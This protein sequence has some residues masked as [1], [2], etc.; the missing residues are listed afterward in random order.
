MWRGAGTSTSCS[1]WRVTTGS[2]RGCRRGSSESRTCSGRSPGWSSG[3]RAWET[4][5]RGTRRRRA[6][7]G[8]GSRRSRTKCCGCVSPAPRRPRPRPWPSIGGCAQV[9][10]KVERL[11][12]DRLHLPW[13]AAEDDLCSRLRLLTRQLQHPAHP[14]NALN[15]LGPV[16]R[17][18]EGTRVCPG[19][20]TNTIVGGPKPK[21]WYMV[22]LSSID[23]AFAIG[24]VK[25]CGER[26]LISLYFSVA[27]C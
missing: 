8:T 20:R 27:I 19:S 15:H 3:S 14:V 2:T 1:R 16:R 9:M 23:C 21:R 25:V 24:R 6:N 7:T 13:T 26:S 11:H 5:T 18:R 4:S 22:A 12:S 17:P 10:G